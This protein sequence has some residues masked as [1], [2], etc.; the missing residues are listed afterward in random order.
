V[1]LACAAVASGQQL[2]DRVV[3]RVNGQPITL[4]DVNAAVALGLVEAPSTPN[5]VPAVTAQL[6]DRQLMLAE[7]A[8]FAPPEPA[9]AAVEREIE[10]LKARAGAKLPVVM[11][12]T[13]L[14]EQR[15]RD[16]VRD[17]LRIQ[18][19]LNQRF[20]EIV[21]VTDDE[22]ERYYR[23]HPAEFTRNGVLMSFEEAVTTAR[24][25]AAVQRRD[26]LIGQWLRDLRARAEVTTRP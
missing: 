12:Q 20:G 22:V 17:T 7:V 10:A 9:A 16:L 5:L 8:R 15:I 21:Q 23:E 26:A 1:L 13:G 11:D 14:D 24:Q 18:A 6:I 3:A 25:R 2:L 4:S 19:Y